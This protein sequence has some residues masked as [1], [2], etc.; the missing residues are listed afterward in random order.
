MTIWAHSVPGDGTQLRTIPWGRRLRGLVLLS[1]AIAG[2]LLPAVPA[3]AINPQIVSSAC[4]ITEIAGAEPDLTVS[5]YGDGGSALTCGFNSPEGVALDVSGN[6]YVADSNN[7]AIRRVDAV[8][9]VITH[10]A[11]TY[12][13]WGNTGDGGP[14]L[15]ALLA[16]PGT[17]RLD[18]QGYLYIGCGGDIPTST[19]N[20]NNVR[21][22]NLATGVIDNYAGITGS[23]GVGSYGGDGGLATQAHLWRPYGL[24]PIPGGGM[25]IADT[26][27]HVIR[28]V[29]AAG[30]ISTV[31]GDNALG[32]GFS[33]DNGPAT[34]AQLDYPMGLYLAA[35]GDLYIADS[36][37]N[38]VRVLHN[39]AIETV[40][41]D[42]VSGTAG[43]GGLATA[44]ELMAPYGVAGDSYGDLF[45]SDQQANLIRMVGADGRISTLA[46]GGA[47]KNGDG[48]A[49]SNS[50]LSYPYDLVCDAAN[51]VFEVERFT[52]RYLYGGNAGE[53]REIFACA[54]A[55][56]ATPTFTA[57]P[58]NTPSPSWTASPSSSFTAS[59]STTPTFT[60]SPSG[61]PGPSSTASPTPS[62]TALPSATPTFTASPSRTPLATATPQVPVGPQPNPFTPG[63]GTN[64]VAVFQLPAGHAAGKLSVYRL[65]GGLLAQASFSAAG[66]VEWDGHDG[67]GGLAESGVYVYVVEAGGRV[68]K[69]T[70]TVLR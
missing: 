54:P 44:A 3:L 24:A 70:V 11:G 58:S 60:A 52:Q 68:W 53:V 49:V 40:A 27:N 36:Y 7:M 43:D 51:D 62:F 48:M 63:L 13:V 6:V 34:A 61:S 57:S 5:P 17:V 66:V 12:N 42:G 46:G 21:R 26:S 32:P 19:D 25:Y 20:M 1:L 4:Y 41:G 29:D 37:N 8:T 45:I 64:R 31:A 14:A 15:S 39:G 56:T 9:G 67:Q 38:R 18:N 50:L 22:V 69:G 23:T 2:G 30:I 10:I 28:K 65:S 33:G 16:W 55:P 35:N 47:V 59:P